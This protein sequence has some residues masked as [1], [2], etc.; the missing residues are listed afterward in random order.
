MVKARKTDSVKDVD[1][2]LAG[3][4][5]QARKTL[6]KLR[7][8]IKTTAPKVEECVSYRIPVYKY[9]GM[10]VGF[11]SFKEHNSFMVMSPPLMKKMKDELKKYSTT[12]GTIHFP[13]DKPRTYFQM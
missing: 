4:P 10:L 3:I 9:N 13:F 11:A 5:K 6:E 12:T 8:T 1:K 7:K 2:Y